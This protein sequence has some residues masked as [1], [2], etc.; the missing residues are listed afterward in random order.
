MRDSS[1]LCIRVY[2]AKPSREIGMNSEIFPRGEK[3]E[4]AVTVYDHFFTG[5][6]RAMRGGCADEHVLCRSVCGFRGRM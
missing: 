1:P 5:T 6:S 2:I 4:K 3:N